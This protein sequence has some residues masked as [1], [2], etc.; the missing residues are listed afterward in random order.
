MLTEI[1]NLTKTSRELDRRWFSD[2]A[3]D[4]Y[5][6]Y[7]HNKKIVEFQISYD[8]DTTDKILSWDTESGF[9]NHNVDSGNVE[10]N[11]MKPSPILTR[12]EQ[13][14]IDYVKIILQPLLRNWN[15]TF[16]NLYSPD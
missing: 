4:L 10:P 7:D 8:K 3:I 12:G 16:I 9:T 11:K 2:P 14:N 15:M 6:W 1:I 13:Q 5:V